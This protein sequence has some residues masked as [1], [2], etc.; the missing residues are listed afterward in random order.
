M[1]GYDDN[2]AR[3]IQLLASAEKAPRLG[4]RLFLFASFKSAKLTHIYFTTQ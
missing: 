3:S 4:S 2:L 1:A